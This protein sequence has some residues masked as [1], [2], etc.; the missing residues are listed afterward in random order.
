[1]NHRS[2]RAG[3]ALGLTLVAGPVLAQGADLTRTLIEGQPSQVQSDE[4]LQDLRG[5][6]DTHTAIAMTEQDLTAINTG[7]QITA[8]V[9]GSGAITL[10]DNALSGFNGIG[11]VMMNTGHNNNLQSSMSV[12]IIVTN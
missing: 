7:N 8:G 1:M 4:D 10:Q 11:N 6:A 3:L 2:L 5:G 12:T 9:V